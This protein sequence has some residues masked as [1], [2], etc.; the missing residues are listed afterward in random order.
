[1]RLLHGGSC[2]EPPTS[3]SSRP[4]PLPSP[5]ALLA[6]L[7]KT[8]A[9]AEFVTRPAPDIHRVIF[10][11][12]RRFLLDRRALLD[13]RP[14]S[15]AR[16]RPPPGRARR[17][18]SDRVMIVMRVYFEKPRTT[19]G[20]KG[21]IMDPHLDGSH[22]IAAG[23]RLARRLPARRAR[24]RAC[25]PRRSCST[26]SPRSTSPTWSAGRRSAPAPP[27]RRPT[28][29]WRPASRCRSASRTAP[30]VRSPPR[31][32]PSAPPP[33]PQTFLGINLDGAASAIVTRATPTA[34]SCSAAAPPARITPPRSRRDRAAPR[35]K[36]A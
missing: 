27:S 1:M 31:S 34:T 32:T 10:T 8:E 33:Q 24:P 7:P 28:G 11:D 35:R 20:W 17:D 3:M 13:P 21:L 22:D 15:R 26:P 14:R 23:L 6:E 19:V 12:D 36:P 5:A 18:V 9:Q 16:L 25:R 30:T 29:R 2:R 4:E